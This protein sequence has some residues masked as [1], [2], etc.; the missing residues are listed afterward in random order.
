VVSAVA[1]SV[2][3]LVVVAVAVAD[4]GSVPRRAPF[5]GLQMRLARQNLSRLLEPNAVVITSERV[6]R[7]AENIEFYGSRVH[8]LYLT[9]LTR[10][11]VRIDQAAALLLARGLRPY[12]FLPP[13]EPARETLASEL[14]HGEFQVE[15]VADI[16]A[17]KA[18]LHF[19]AA[20]SHGGVPMQLDRISHPTL[21]AARR[22]LE[23][24]RAAQAG[25]ASSPSR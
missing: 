5:Q 6:G 2:L 16:P 14:A 21:E 23:Q 24:G 12:L 11:N 22:A 1:G 19:V 18:M 25:G 17:N 8:A 20:P 13:D 3:M 9:D 7:P 10:W 15:R 4:T